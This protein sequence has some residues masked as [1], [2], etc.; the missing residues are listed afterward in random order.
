ME[1]T[2][3][4]GLEEEVATAQIGESGEDAASA[5]D[6]VEEELPG[7]QFVEEPVPVSEGFWVSFVEEG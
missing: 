1:H 5:V 4:A 7:G 6:H 2:P 3:A